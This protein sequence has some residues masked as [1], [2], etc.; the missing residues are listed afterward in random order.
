MKKINFVRLWTRHP[1]A[2]VAGC[3]LIVIFLMSVLAPIVT[4]HSYEEQDI[5]MRLMAYAPSYPLGTDSLGRDLYSRILYGARVSLAVGLVTAFMS[6]I[7]GVILGGVAGYYGGIIDMLLMRLVDGLYIFPSLLIAILVMVIMG[8]GLAAILVAL[9]LTGWV[10]MARIVRGQVLQTKE[11][12]YVESAR[13]LG[14]GDMSILFR[15][16]LPNLWGPIFVALTYQVPSNIMAE[17]FLSFLGIGLQPPYSSWGTLAAEGWR[18]MRS[19]PHLILYPGS[20]LF[21][22]LMAFNFLGDGLRD[23]LDPKSRAIWPN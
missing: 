6:L 19:Y 23:W 17:S 11:A 3:F 9:G 5:S 12:L 14:L 2:T 16:I 1:L 4:A 7:F 8:Q 20:V 21:L 18:A 15:H 13:A 22:C 10:T